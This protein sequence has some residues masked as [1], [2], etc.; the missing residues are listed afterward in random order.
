MS[1]SGLIVIDKAPGPGSHDV[2]RRIRRVLNDKRVGHAGTLDPFASG[3]L[4]VLVGHATLLSQFLVLDE[5][6]YTARLRWG[7]AT[8]TQDGEGRMIETSTAPVPDEAA[9]AAAMARFTGSIDQ[10]PPMFSAKKVDG[11]PLHKLARK[12]TEIERAPVPVVVHELRLADNHDDGW[13]FFVRCS[14]GTYVRTLAHDMAI[15]L[16]GLGHLTSLRRLSSGPFALDRAI[17][18]D[19]FEA[20]AIASGD[21]ARVATELGIA[22][23]DA[24]PHL[25]ILTLDPT[26]TWD[27][28]NGR[29]LPLDRLPPGGEG[30]LWR[31]V[32]ERGQMIAVATPRFDKGAWKT[33]RVFV[34]AVEY[35]RET[36]SPQ[37]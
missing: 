18:L 10:V 37:E 15:A 2:V 12:G 32:D 26:D 34:D 31:C 7:A 20:R 23:D 22:F 14:K 21:A 29:L 13:S 17:S 9:I 1:F 36:G 27:L 35:R 33:K 19:D 3:V 11:R 8:D 6:S 16:G 5:K 28:I 30:D 24:L 4:V 25:P